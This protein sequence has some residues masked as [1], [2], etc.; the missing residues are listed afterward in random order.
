MNITEQ[1]AGSALSLKVVPLEAGQVTGKGFQ[2]AK[3]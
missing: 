1:S 2:S 3:E